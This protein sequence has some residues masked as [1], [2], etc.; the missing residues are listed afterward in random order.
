MGATSPRETALDALESKHNTEI[1]TKIV[2]QTTSNNS[3]DHA[4]VARSQTHTARQV[5]AALVLAR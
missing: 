3:S 1:K 2:T 5:A 4:Y